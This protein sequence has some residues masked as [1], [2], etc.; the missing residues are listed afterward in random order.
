M[1]VQV[2]QDAGFWVYDR[3]GQV[4]ASSVLGHTGAVTLPEEGMVVFAGAPGARF[5]LR[6]AA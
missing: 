4:V 2:P 5:H 1:T 6:F 3:D